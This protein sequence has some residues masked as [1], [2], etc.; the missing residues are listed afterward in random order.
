[1]HRWEEKAGFN[2]FYQY[3]STP[4]PAVP[5]SAVVERS[6][7]VD[8]TSR[9]T[10]GGK[11]TW[12]VPKGKWVILRMGYSLT[13]AKKPSRATN[14]LRLRSRQAKQQVCRGILPRIHRSAGAGP[15]PAVRKKPA[16]CDDG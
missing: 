7:I 1:M 5:L 10:S 16:L 11:L 13:G 12:E 6:E 15:G 14:R 9:M 2:F 8:L 3:E 4:T